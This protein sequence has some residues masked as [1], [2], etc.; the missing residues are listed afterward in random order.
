MLHPSSRLSCCLQS[1]EIS[2]GQTDIIM[3][4]SCDRRMQAVLFLKLTQPVL[5]SLI[6]LTPSANAHTHTHVHNKAKRHAQ[7]SGCARPHTHECAAQTDAEV[8]THSTAS[9]CLGVRHHRESCWLFSLLS[10]FLCVWKGE[11][12]HSSFTQINCFKTFSCHEEFGLFYN[13]KTK[14]FQ[15]DSRVV[16]LLIKEKKNSNVIL[17]TLQSICCRAVNTIWS[18]SL[19]C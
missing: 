13:F 8:C 16:Q 7:G 10:Y 9:S 19:R 14:T 1:K 11:T 12:S 6:Q 3:L 17:D 15:Y 5:Y 18:L 4:I 2:L